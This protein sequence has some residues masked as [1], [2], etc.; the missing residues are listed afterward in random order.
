MVAGVVL[1]GEPLSF[2]EFSTWVQHPID[3]ENTGNPPLRLPGTAAKCWPIGS[4]LFIQL[5]NGLQQG[6]GMAVIS[7]PLRRGC[8]PLALQKLHRAGAV[9][10]GFFPGIGSQGLDKMQREAEHRVA[11]RG[12]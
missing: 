8:S 7:A 1:M 12:E 11:P 2:F 6:T 10:D 5:G 3:Q 4:H 9:N